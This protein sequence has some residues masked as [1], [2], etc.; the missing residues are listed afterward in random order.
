MGLYLIKDEPGNYPTVLVDYKS[1][2][3]MAISQ[4]NLG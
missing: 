4:K 2:N 1:M 3:E